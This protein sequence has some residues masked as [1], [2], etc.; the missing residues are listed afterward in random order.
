MIGLV[1]AQA[2][3]LEDVYSDDMSTTSSDGI[4]LKTAEK[5]SHRL[6]LNCGLLV[7]YFYRHDVIPVTQ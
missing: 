2:H 5:R 1:G 4:P 3:Y 6:C 7:R